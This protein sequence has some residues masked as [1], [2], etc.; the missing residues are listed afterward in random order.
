MPRG[1][2]SELGSE[3]VSQNGY[4]YVKTPTGWRLKH[5]IIA[6]ETIGRPLRGDER[7]LFDDHKKDNFDP[8]NLTVVTSKAKAR[9]IAKLRT[10]L[11]ALA[12]RVNRLA[13]ALS[14]LESSEAD[15]D[16]S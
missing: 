2:T 1:E 11:D 7:V 4:T 15:D 6:E 5:H 10:D 12:E 9:K 8:N 16:D 13:E 14:T 3:K